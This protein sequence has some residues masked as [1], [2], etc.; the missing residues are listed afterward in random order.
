MKH[1]L[2]VHMAAM[3]PAAIVVLIFILSPLSLV[4]LSAPGWLDG[5]VFPKDCFL[6][7]LTSMKSALPLFLATTAGLG[8]YGAVLVDFQ[9]AQPP[10]SPKTAK[11]CTHVLIE[12]V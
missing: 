11:Q 4:F 8:V 1:G 5:L 9:V 12:C 6:A 2:S 3:V 7:A 10:P